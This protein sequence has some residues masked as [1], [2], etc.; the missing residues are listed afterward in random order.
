M[1]SPASR[2]KILHL[3][4]GLGSGGA[5]RLLHT[6]LTQ[7][8]RTKF[9][10]EVV[11]VFSGRDYWKGPI[12][13]LGIKVTSLDR[14]GQRSVVSG[15]TRLRQH[16]RES[17]PDL[18][19]THLWAANVIGRI[20]GGL[21]R[22][23]VISSI[24]APEYEK[25]TM[26]D[27]THRV[28]FAI[29]AA[30]LL[31]AV[32]AKFWCTRML[33]VSRFAKR[34]TQARLGYP[35]DRID[36]LYNPVISDESP[37]R[38]PGFFASDGVPDSATVIVSVGRVVPQKGSIYAVRAMPAILKESPDSH[39][40][41]VGDLG[42][43]HYVGL[44]RNEIERMNIFAN[45]H[46]IGERPNVVEYLRNADVFVFP[47]VYEGMGIAL[48]EAMFHS[49]ACAVS[50]IEPFD[51]FIEDGVSGVYFESRDPV[52]LARKVVALLRDP[53]L[54]EQLGNEAAKVAKE[55]FDAKKAAQELT[56]LYKKVIGE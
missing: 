8:D 4:E 47:S 54:R 44:V 13:K 33:A 26:A 30:Q 21:E 55:K 16:L 14:K 15:V 12:E 25:E 18:I 46:L 35:S 45:V 37:P 10:H 19:H 48:A 34:S 52:D 1:A 5:E 29:R 41:F 20:A 17:R 38:D 2:R 6:N 32:T 43:E 11:T 42:N 27:A 3:I 7:I 39:L 9:D 24:H 49:C 36:V 22:I 31:D 28:R 53:Q 51:E 56:D 23:P 50:R 40:V